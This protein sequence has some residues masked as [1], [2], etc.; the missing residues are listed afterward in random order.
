MFE[1]NPINNRMVLFGFN[2]NDFYTTVIPQYDLNF[3]CSIANEHL[4]FADSKITVAFKSCDAN[5]TETYF[6][7]MQE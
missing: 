1:P 7:K 5:P 3:G 4:S 2:D 6:M